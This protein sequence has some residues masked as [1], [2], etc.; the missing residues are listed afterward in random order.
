VTDLVVLVL[1]VL[2]VAVL[3][4][5]A[6]RHFREGR[7]QTSIESF[8]EQLH[9]LERTGPKLVQPA[10]RLGSDDPSPTM[11]PSPVGFPGGTARSRSRS[12]L[13]LLDHTEAPVDTL[14]PPQPVRT[15]RPAASRRRGRRRRRDILLAL[16]ATAALTGGVGAMH[17]LHALWIVMAVSIL[18]IAGYVALAAYAQVLDA[19]RQALQPVAPSRP[20]PLPSPW[21]GTRPRHAPGAPMR[22]V[23]V[24]TG[25]MSWAAR[26]GY[27]GA[28]DEDEPTPRHAHA[29]GG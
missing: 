9:L 23:E 8:H 3:A 12:G 25:Q 19:D 29:A 21:D 15:R 2:W 16:V 6:I 5:R 28:W 24:L 14:A 20:Q 26:A 22:G 13:V 7:S 17:G 1:V 18:A 11:A 10:Y 4:P 27:P